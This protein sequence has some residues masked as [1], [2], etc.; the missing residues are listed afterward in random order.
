MVKAKEKEP[1]DLES[2]AYVNRLSDFLFVFAR[3]INIDSGEKEVTW[4]QQ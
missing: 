3:K 2:L 1:V 4:S